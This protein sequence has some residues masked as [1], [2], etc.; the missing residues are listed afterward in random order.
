MSD[1]TRLQT[2]GD[3]IPSSTEAVALMWAAELR[4]YNWQMMKATQRAGG[5]IIHLWK[6]LGKHMAG[7]VFDYLWYAP[8]D[9]W[10]PRLSWQPPLVRNF[11]WYR[12]KLECECWT[13]VGDS[14]SSAAS[15]SDDDD[16]GDMS[17]DC[18]DY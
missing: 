3:A 18:W 15:S 1:I 17:D 12:S 2:H 10:F 13:A 6:R 5:I 7:C 8:T 4:E 11:V 14:G 9:R 16:A